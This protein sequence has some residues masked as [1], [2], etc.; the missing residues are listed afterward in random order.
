MVVCI[1]LYTVPQ[2]ALKSKLVLDCIFDF[3]SE[4]RIVKGYSLSPCF[5]SLCFFPGIIPRFILVDQRFLP[6]FCTELF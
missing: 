5:S 4:T 1:Y 6:I 3:S 2:K